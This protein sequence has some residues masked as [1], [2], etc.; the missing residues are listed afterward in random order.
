[1]I[2]L[3]FLSPLLISLLCVSVAQA[4]LYKKIDQQGRVLFTDKPEGRGYKLIM[5]TPQKGTVAY[6]HFE[7]NRRKLTPLIRQQAKKHKV[8]SALVMA[9]IHA[10]SAYDQRAIS[11]AGAVGLMQLMP[12]TAERFGVTN[13]NN[14]AQN[15][16][17]G[18][19]YLRHLLELFKF[20]IRLALAAYNAGESTVAKY[21]NKIPPYPE[22][23]TYV[24]RVVKHYQY[25][26]SDN[27]S[28]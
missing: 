18:T 13:R 11:R 27:K 14:P 12:K 2:V 9:V 25:Y 19:R 7:R 3:R 28:L 16:S 4:D 20:D 17:G 6:R 8:D 26:L 1:M 22:T 24:K 10:E 15:I 23:Q 5:R 21:G